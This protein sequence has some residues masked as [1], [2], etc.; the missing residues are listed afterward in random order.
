[1]WCCVFA[2]AEAV[3]QITATHYNLSQE[4]EFVFTEGEED[5]PATHCNCNSLQHPATQC[6]SLHLTA[7]LYNLTATHY[8]LL[9]ELESMRR[10]CLQRE[11]R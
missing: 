10:L 1:M 9:R 6:D 8:N 11:R 3:Q 4:L 5:S 7:T 2:E